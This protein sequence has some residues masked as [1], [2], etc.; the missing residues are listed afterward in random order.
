MLHRLPALLESRVALGCCGNPWQSHT[1]LQPKQHNNSENLVTGKPRKSTGRG[2]P[3]FW[4]TQ[5]GLINDVQCFAPPPP[6]LWVHRILS[7]RIRFRRVRFQTPN[8]VSFFALAE[9]Q[10]ESS[11]SSARPIICVR[12]RTHRVFRRTHRVCPRTVSLSEFSLRFTVL[13]KQYSARFLNSVQAKPWRRMRRAK[14]HSIQSGRG[15]PKLTFCMQSLTS[16]V[17]KGD[18]A[19]FNLQLEFF[20]LQSSFLAYSPLRPLLLLLSYCEQKSSC[21]VSK[22][23]K[24]VSQSSS[25]CVSKK[26]KKL[27]L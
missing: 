17:K 12:K 23:A 15:H 2:F 4:E 27:Q 25:N 6:P 19:C 16:S 7:S 26:L 24:I 11:V 1:E 5:I 8:S 3:L 14:R 22:K 9:F 10:E 18:K 13:S 20:C 21:C